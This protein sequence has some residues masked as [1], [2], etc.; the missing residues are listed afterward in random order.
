MVARKLQEKKQC[1]PRRKQ[2]ATDDPPCHERGRVIAMGP[3]NGDV[4]TRVSKVY[5]LYMRQIEVEIT[6]VRG[7]SEV[8]PLQYNRILWFCRRLSKC[9]KG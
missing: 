8:R 4:D 2:H 6:P 9:Q 3:C 7:K 1:R 5:R